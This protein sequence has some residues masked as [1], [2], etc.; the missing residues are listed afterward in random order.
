ME[1]INLEPNWKNLQAQYG[2][3]E[4]AEI[5]SLFDELSELSDLIWELMPKVAKGTSYDHLDFR[6]A[7][8]DL[9]ILARKLV[10]DRSKVFSIPDYR[11]VNHGLMKWDMEPSVEPSAIQLMSLLVGRNINAS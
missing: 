2:I 7:I 4:E 11:Q 3:Q 10:D 5:N 9:Q 6:E 1:T 8:S